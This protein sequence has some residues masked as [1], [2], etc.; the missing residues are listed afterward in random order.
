VTKGRTT[1]HP[2][3]AFKMAQSRLEAAA[4]LQAIKAKK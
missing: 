3:A 2:D 1:M 4:A